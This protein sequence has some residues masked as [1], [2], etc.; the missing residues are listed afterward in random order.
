[1]KRFLLLLLL[2][3]TLYGSEVTWIDSYEQALKT[4]KNEHKPMLLFMNKPGCGSCEYMKENVFT[5]EAVVKYLEQNY[6]SVSLSIHKN[7]AP[8]ELKVSVTP[9]F[10]F[11]SSDGSKLRETLIGGK[12]APFFLKLLKQADPSAA[13]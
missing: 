2:S 11:L 10:H 1:M 12:T 9:V 5:D 4:A 7:D 6:V 3:V 8:K 13:K